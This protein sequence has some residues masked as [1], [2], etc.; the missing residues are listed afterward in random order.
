MST[1]TTYSLSE[2]MRAFVEQSLHFAPA[3]DSLDARREAFLAACRHFTPPTPEGVTLEDSQVG[4]IAVRLYRPSGSAPE[5]GWP[6][7]LYLH[8]GGWDLG[9]L[10][11]HDWFAFAILHRLRIAI[12][13][14]DYRLAPEHPF[15]APLEDC[16]TVWHALRESHVAADLSS[17]RLAVGGDSAG[18]TLA[19]GLCIALREEGREQPLLQ[20]LF[21]PVLTAEEQLPS[22]KEHANAPLM[23]LAGL[24]K[25]ISGFLPEPAVRQDPRA[26]PL[27]AQHFEGLAPAFI[28][29][30][31]YDPLRDHGYAYGNSLRNAGVPAELHLGKGL[32]H[33]CLRASGVSQVESLFDALGSA[34]RGLTK[35]A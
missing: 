3:N 5:D 9:N 14:V 34:L 24:R 11:S 10:D 19:A 30:A 4:D 16:L 35:S 29:L 12:V 27:M 2:P 21:Y 6:T 31:E 18:G 25:S 17:K 28:G 20:A 13:A 23:T 8:G 1:T 15:P 33:S 26:M 32:M 7:L 22:M